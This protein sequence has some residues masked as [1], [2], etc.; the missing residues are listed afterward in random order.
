[1]NKTFL[2]VRKSSYLYYLIIGLVAKNLEVLLLF[3]YYFKPIEPVKIVFL[4]VFF[5]KA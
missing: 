4:I 5:E 3:L 1:M 2:K